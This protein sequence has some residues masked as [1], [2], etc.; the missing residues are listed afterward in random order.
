VRRPRLPPPSPE[1]LA[2][3]ALWRTLTDLALLGLA[4]FWMLDSFAPPQD[5]YW[6]PLRLADPPGLMTR[7]KFARAADDRLAC[8]AILREGGV[9][10][11]EAPERTDGACAVLNAGRLGRGVT[12]L[13]PAAP[14]MTCPEALAYAFWDRHA[15]RP[16]AREVLGREVASVSH[17]GTFACRNVYGRGEARR[18]EHAFANALDV[19]AF[20]LKGGGQVSVLADF[21]DAGPRG[22]FLRRVRDE[23]CDWFKV[24]LSPDY[25]AAHA[26]HFH[27]DMGRWRACA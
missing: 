9:T 17:F 18:S 4:L 23:A 3:G 20:R 21:G 10:F 7:V 12:P 25:N 1:V 8:R 27:L 19:S 15:L 26:N 6:K 22:A 13:S 24:T 16:A 14:V 11:T 5:L 2:L